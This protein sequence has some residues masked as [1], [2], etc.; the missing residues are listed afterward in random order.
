MLEHS[1]A[2]HAPDYFS[3]F[4]LLTGFLF[5]LNAH[6]CLKMLYFFVLTD[7]NVASCF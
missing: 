1:K 5:R 3:F 2:S 4:S 7:L 6:G